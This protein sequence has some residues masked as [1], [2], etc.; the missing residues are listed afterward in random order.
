M[1][2]LDFAHA[3]A[4]THGGEGPLRANRGVSAVATV[5]A[6]KRVPADP[7][8]ARKHEDAQSARPGAVKG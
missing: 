8:P 7:Y 5:A 2:V 6:V 4:N 3:H 1:Q